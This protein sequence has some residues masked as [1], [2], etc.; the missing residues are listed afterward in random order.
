[1]GAPLFGCGK[2][3][4]AVQMCVE[5]PWTARGL[6]TRLVERRCGTCREGQRH[7]GAHMAKARKSTPRD[8]Q[9][10]W[11]ASLI[12]GTPGRYLGHVQAKDQATA[13]ERAA[14][15]FDVP[16]TLRDRIVVAIDDWKL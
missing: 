1:M 7:R 6:G 14:K 3:P 10:R 11:R 16:D 5:V 9:H 8:F 13:I 2:R 15:E 4:P 12:R